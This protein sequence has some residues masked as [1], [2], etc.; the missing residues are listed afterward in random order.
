MEDFISKTDST[1]G[2][3]AHKNYSEDDYVSFYISNS[4]L[5]EWEKEEHSEILRSR[6]RNLRMQE[7]MA[8]KLGATVG[9]LVAEEIEN[10]PISEVYLVDCF[11][12]AYFANTHQVECLNDSLAAYN[13]PNGEQ[14]IAIQMLTSLYSSY[15]SVYGDYKDIMSEF[16]EIHSNHFFNSA[17]E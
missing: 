3:K 11:Y 1:K 16:E 14:G 9:D 17:F 6:Y 13:V 2:A 12:F 8:A 15:G 7:E 4:Q 5:N 10:S